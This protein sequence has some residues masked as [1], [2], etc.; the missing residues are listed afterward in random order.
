VSGFFSNHADS[1]VTGPCGLTLILTSIRALFL[2][3]VL[4]VLGCSEGAPSG[5]S[6]PPSRTIPP[7]PPEHEDL[8]TPE[9]WE[10]GWL[11]Q[12][13]LADDEDGITSADL[14][15]ATLAMAACAETKG[16][17]IVSEPYPVMAG[18]SWGI[19]FGVENRED[20]EEGMLI[21]DAC[22]DAWKSYLEMNRPQ[23]SEVEQHNLLMALLDCLEANGA[24]AVDRSL[25]DQE[26][27]DIVTEPG[28]RFN[29]FDA[30]YQH[31]YVDF[32]DWMAI[33]PG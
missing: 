14:K 9:E 22:Q 24:P 10:E 8:I 31:C 12:F 28:S 1:A 25:S 7:L 23:K 5:S 3:L 17:L 18:D 11:F 4:A 32:A 27:R 6:S 29:H 16:V 13:R 15:E 20:G 33:N 2:V 26:I 21:S 19:N 30:R